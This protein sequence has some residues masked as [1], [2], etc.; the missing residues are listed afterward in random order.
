[1]SHKYNYWYSVPDD[2]I[3]WRLRDYTE[4]FKL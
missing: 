1:M 4:M 2:A 3:K